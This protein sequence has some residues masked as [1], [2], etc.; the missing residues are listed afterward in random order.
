MSATEK[1]EI[2]IRLAEIARSF[3][4]KIKLTVKN[5]HKVLESNYKKIRE[6]DNR[7]SSTVISLK[8]AA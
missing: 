2:N 7:I 6:I 1:R 8:L 5:A 4:L 3:G